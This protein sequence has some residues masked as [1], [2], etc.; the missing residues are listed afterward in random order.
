MKI[1]AR[2]AEI[3][4]QPSTFG[5]NWN[6]PLPEQKDEG[7]A[8]S[9][10]GLPQQQEIPEWKRHI[11]G[12][13][14]KSLNPLTP[15][16]TLVSPFTEISILFSSFFSFQ[17]YF[18]RFFVSILFSLFFRFN[19]IFVVFSFQFYF[20]RFFVSILFSSFFRFNSIFVVFSFQ[21]YFRRFFVVFFVVF[22]NIT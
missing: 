11:T 10:R 3:E 2:D 1:A 18:F 7:P 5:Q 6:D 20:R 14:L 9:S 19:S 4:A 21:F 13:G 22:R 12:G 15:R 8:A 17:F 16:R